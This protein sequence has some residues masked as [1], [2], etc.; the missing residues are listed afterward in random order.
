MHEGKDKMKKLLLVLL[1]FI[2]LGAFTHSFASDGI[3]WY[4]LKDGMEKAKQEKMPLIVDFWYGEGCPRCARMQKDIYGDPL[5]VKKIMDDFIPIKIDLAKALTAEEEAL[6]DKYEYK[7]ECLLLF[8]D[9]NGEVLSDTGG[10]RLCFMDS[11]DPE[12]FVSYLDMVK[13]SYKRK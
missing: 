5:I 3:Q 6:G 2:L 9:H 4:S 13:R 1:S 8:L 7:H 10:K 12:W 11:V